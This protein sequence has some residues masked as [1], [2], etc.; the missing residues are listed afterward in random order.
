[1]ALR[2]EPGCN[3]PN[4]KKSQMPKDTNQRAAAIVAQA[5][6]DQVALKPMHFKR[7]PFTP[8]ENLAGVEYATP[9]EETSNATQR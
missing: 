8:V 5:T 7:F 9:K 4:M 6:G 2:L 3:I 1:M